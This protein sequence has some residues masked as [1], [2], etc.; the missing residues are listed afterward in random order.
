VR[1]FLGVTQGRLVPPLDGQLQCFPQASWAHE[2]SLAAEIGLDYV[3]WLAEQQHNPDNPIWSAEGLEQIRAA[4]R[5]AGLRPYSVVND[6]VIDHD[7][8]GPGDALAQTLRLLDQAEAL[9]L[10]TLVL[11]LYEASEVQ[12]HDY[13][14]FRDPLR[15][16]ADRTAGANILFCLE[17]ILTGAAFLEL[18]DIV[19]RAN[20]F[21]CFDLGNRIALRQDVCGDIRLVGSLIRHIHIKDKDDEGRNVFLGTGRLDF[22]RVF[23]ALASMSYRDAFTFETL[24]GRDP[25]ETAKFHKM[26]VEFFMRETS[27]L[28][29]AGV[30]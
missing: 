13:R 19:D 26:F 9:G 4:H 28:G 12:G 3:E 29:V 30:R 17:T 7:L 15:E 27:L 10:R 18:I 5:R 2:L 6:Y 23:E 11:P 21:A 22:Y 16:I 20:V 8:T 24:R 25:V 14:R 1:P